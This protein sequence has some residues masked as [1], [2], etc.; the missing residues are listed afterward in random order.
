[1]T[2]L[3]LRH[4]AWGMI[5]TSRNTRTSKGKQR[6]FYCRSEMGRN[7]IYKLKIFQKK[8]SNF[9]CSAAGTTWRVWTVHRPVHEFRHR[10]SFRA[11]YTDRTDFPHPYIRYMF[12]VFEWAL[13]P[14]RLLRVAKSWCS[15]KKWI[16]IDVVT[17]TMT[18]DGRCHLCKSHCRDARTGG[19]FHVNNVGE[20]CHFKSSTCWPLS[21]NQIP[22]SAMNSFNECEQCSDS[23]VCYSFFLQSIRHDLIMNLLPS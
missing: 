1:M 19:I 15:V 7:K 21:V 5:Q 14:L 6:P 12:R 17:S 8:R 16:Q 2:S 23:S 18:F 9:F 13:S 4:N 10:P 20:Y 22:Y 3:N 11:P